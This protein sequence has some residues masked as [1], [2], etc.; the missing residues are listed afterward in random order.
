[1]D[2]TTDV[3]KRNLLTINTATGALTPVTGSPFAGGAFLKSIAVDPSGRFVYVTDNG[4][5]KVSAFAINA[6]SGA[7]TPVAGSPFAAGIQPFSV[8]TV[9]F[10]PPAY[11]VRYAVN[12]AIGIRDRQER[13]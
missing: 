6:S 1:M 3:L 9:R 8:V 10:N 4:I 2:D 7:L 5:A 13:T 12:L 11:L